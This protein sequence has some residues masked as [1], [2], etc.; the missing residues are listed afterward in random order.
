MA[1]GS[2]PPPA[3]PGFRCGRRRL[4]YGKMSAFWI[5][6]RIPLR[7]NPEASGTHFEAVAEAIVYQ[8]LSG[9]AAA[10][11]YGR[12]KALYDN[13]PPSPA[14]L[15]AST[16]ESLRASGLSGQK[17]RYLKDLASRAESGDVAFD[18]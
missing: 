5:P 1:A 7:R 8:Q 9:K 13:K 18:S 16:D 3:S 10:T 17:T 12:V 14:Q 4:A 2:I 6:T 15:L 11:I